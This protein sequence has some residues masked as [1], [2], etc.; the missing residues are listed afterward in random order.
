[1]Q[2]HG[3]S[4]A[5]ACL[6][7]WS[8]FHLRQPGE[9]GRA[10]EGQHAVAVVIHLS[11]GQALERGWTRSRWQGN[12][13]VLPTDSL[14]VLSDLLP[15]RRLLSQLQTN[16]SFV[17]WFQMSELG[18]IRAQAFLAGIKDWRQRQTGLHCFFSSCQ[19]PGASNSKQHA[20]FC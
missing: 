4:P 17:R 14:D 15:P 16:S 11:H 3:T 18:F 5:T 6:N 7:W 13:C 20:P 2:S 8:G 10:G 9:S 1:M 12:D 19:L